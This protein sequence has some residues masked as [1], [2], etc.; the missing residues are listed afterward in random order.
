MYGVG[1]D[2]AGDG[3]DALLAAADDPTPATARAAAGDAPVA[4][5]GQGDPQEYAWLAGGLPP[6]LP[7]AAPQA[8]QPAGVGAGGL[9]H[10]TPGGPAANDAGGGAVPARGFG[11]RRNAGSGRKTYTPQEY[12]AA[13]A[14]IKPG[15]ERW[16][17]KET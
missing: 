8:A 3:F 14:G 12:A 15:C 17:V 4:A 13:A 10:Q 2:G 11:G 9:P 16:N 6:M 1:F 7:P 5:P